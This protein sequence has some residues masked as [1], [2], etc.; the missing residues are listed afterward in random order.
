MDKDSTQRNLTL[1]PGALHASKATPSQPLP[2]AEDIF[3]DA[4][5]Y[6]K[7]LRHCIEQAR[8]QIDMEVYIYESKRLGKH[9]SD[10]LKRA[11]QRGLT[12]RLLTD[13][14]G[15]NQDFQSTARDLVAHGV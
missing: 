3:N 4:E 14:Y 8:F 2:L 5:S 7:A 10:A 1:E 15:I 12:V 11:A 13:G 6:F 9:V